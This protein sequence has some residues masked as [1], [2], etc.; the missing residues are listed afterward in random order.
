MSTT[1]FDQLRSRVLSLVAA[2]DMD[3]PAQPALARQL[4]ESET[5]RFQRDLM[6]GMQHGLQPFSDPPDVVD[7]LMR[8]LIG[9]GAQLDQLVSDP[10]VEEIYGVDGDITARLVGGETRCTESPAQPEAVLA[11]LQ[12]TYSGGGG[13]H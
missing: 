11:V 6:R 1:A 10:R 3:V 8:E 4:V 12:R 2:R 9:I 13:E 5:E 7:R